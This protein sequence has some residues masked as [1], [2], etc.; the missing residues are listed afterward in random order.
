LRRAEFTGRDY[1]SLIAGCVLETGFLR[2][3][4]PPA[5]WIRQ[6][7]QQRGGLLLGMSAFSDGVDH[8]YT[9]GYWMDC[10]ARDE[11]KRVL[12]GFY[13]SLAYGMSRDTYSS[14]EVTHL[15][16]GRNELTL[17]QQYSH[18]QQIRLLRNM[19]VRE[20]R[21]ELF[22]GQAIPRPWLADGKQVRVVRAPTAFGEVG[23]TLQ[24]RD[25]GR[26][27]VATVTPPTRKPPSAIR[28]RTRHAENRPIA[29]VSV[30]GQ[31]WS[32]FTADTV[33]LKPAGQL[34]SIEIRYGD[35][36]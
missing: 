25:A 32:E 31:P 5:G 13:G 16:D 19:L 11:I 8:A 29:S 1:Y 33:V 30:N 15:R 9:Y 7:L 24:S 4:D 23:Y 6:L 3:D 18:T 14:V 12:L 36:P 17:P 21:D 34:L 22:L 2:P 20:V 28:L 10:L 35:R 27:I 26:T